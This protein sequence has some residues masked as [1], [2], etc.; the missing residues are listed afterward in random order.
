M[1]QHANSPVAAC[2]KFAQDLILYYYGE[3]GSSERHQVD[4]HIGGCE[5]CRLYLQQLESFLPMTVAADD[6]PQAFW[7]DYSREMR[8]KLAAVHEPKPWWRSWWSL[9]QPWM[10]PVMA[11]TAVV[12]LAL[13]FTVGKRFWR[14]NELP[15]DE[16]YF[17]ESLPMTEDLDFFSNMEVLD[18]MDMLEFMSGQGSGAV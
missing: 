8:R 2:E 17:M 6:P 18:A 1:V 16:A 13:T 4:T 15:Q 12:L 9:F 10:A 14:A 11:T 3:L 7:D 5:T